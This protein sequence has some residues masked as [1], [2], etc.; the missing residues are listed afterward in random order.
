MVRQRIHIFLPLSQ[1][2]RG[3]RA[4]PKGAIM[5][6]VV[7]SPMGRAIME[8]FLQH[9]SLYLLEQA[10]GEDLELLSIQKTLSHRESRMG[11]YFIIHSTS[12]RLDSIHLLL[13]SFL[14]LFYRW[15]ESPKQILIYL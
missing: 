12:R 3:A 13:L 15:N 6:G 10:L 8:E 11:S 5:I 14:L 9:F 2:L 7:H 1:V 4:I